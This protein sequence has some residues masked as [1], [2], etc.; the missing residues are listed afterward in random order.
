MAYLKLNKLIIFFLIACLASSLAAQK[1]S[2][3]VL[4]TNNT[5]GALE[6][7]YCPDNPFGSIEKRSIYVNNFI[8]EN[9]NTVLLDAGDFVTMSQQSLK[10]SLVAE[11]YG[12][13]PYD[14]LLYGDQELVMDA[15]TLNRLRGQLSTTLVGTNIDRSD[16]F[17]SKIIRRK[18]LRIAVMGIVDPY[19]IKYYP[20]E[21]KNRI[22]LSDPVKAVK[23]E[24][25]KLSNRADIFILMTHQGYDLD[26]SIAKKI[27]GLDLIIGAHSQSAI[28][29]PKEV[30]G[31]LIVQ[32][33][34]S[35]YYIGVV[36]IKMNKGKVVE[37][38]GRLD[39]MK[40]EMPDDPRIMQMIEE[41]ENKSGR[42]N[43][44]KQKLKEKSDG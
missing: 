30:N 14:A 40:F 8:K 38:S 24:M 28:E 29:S 5:N 37:K 18:G 27:D 36:E 7:C 39:T 17:T 1:K 23:D 33:G 12:L 19:S 25:K 15:R 42:M 31:A 26:L 9:P 22:R 41:Y 21:I 2:L 6:N 44:R 10:D 20:D 4:H 13:L 35:G 34:K 11:A 3:Y 32:A 43:R 16:L